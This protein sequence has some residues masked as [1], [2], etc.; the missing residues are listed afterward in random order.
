MDLINLSILVLIIALIYLF[1]RYL[2]LKDEIEKRALEL[3]K[4]WKDIELKKEVDEK[5]NLLF[6]EW[7]QKE[8]KNIRKDAIKRS[9]AIVRGKITENLIPYFPEFKYNPKDAKFIGS[10]VD[11]I[12]FDGL[13]GGNLKKIVFIEVK[14]GKRGILSNREKSIKKCVENKNIEYELI[15]HKIGSS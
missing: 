2:K 7:K 14:T 13:S 1:W 8:E 12:V 10:P 3:F 6:K 5:A 11:F 15:H 9:E 4:E